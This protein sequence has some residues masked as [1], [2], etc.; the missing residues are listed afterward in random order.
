MTIS[1]IT[2]TYNSAN[3]LK[4]YFSTITNQNF[5]DLEIIIIDSGSSDTTAEIVAEQKARRIIFKKTG[6]LGF[7]A[8]NN[9]AAGLASGK[10]LFFLNPDTKLEKNCLQFLAAKIKVIKAED[11]IM[12]PRQ[13]NYETKKFAND[14]V[15][16][17]IFGYPY[18][19]FDADNPSKT[20]SVSFC[21]GA[22]LFLPKNTFNRL[23]QFDQDLFMF[24]DDVDLCWKARLLG[25]PLINC[26]QS[27]VYHY[28]GGSLRGGDR[29]AEIY[30]TSYL[31]RYLGER[32][33]I[34]NILKNYLFLT[35][36]WVL[37]LYLTINLLEMLVF[38]LSGHPK[39]VFQYLKA[40]WWNIVNIKSTLAKRIEIQR[41]RNVGDLK[42]FKNLYF[43]SG[44]LN[45]FLSIKI[46]EFE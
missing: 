25:F 17:D 6:N 24:N 36:L 40:W 22:A 20:K 28:S 15:C 37:P 10:Y 9:L 35:L 14:G 44:K 2:V 7:A 46:P 12:I 29:K 30:K 27:V 26:P 38:L 34:R 21:D 41:I 18:K 13:K 45:A 1:I 39:V 4:E 31:R 32:N 8:G 43:G 33:A 5:D 42:I 16:V 3:F 19:I 23:G 11:F